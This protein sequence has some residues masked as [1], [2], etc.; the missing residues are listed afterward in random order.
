MQ[1]LEIDKSTTLNE[2]SDRLGSDLNSFL[3]VNNMQRVPNVGE[4]Y[5]E[6][7]NAIIAES[8]PVSASRK[9]SILSSMTSDTDIFQKAAL[10][11]VDG[12]KLTS[13]RNVLPGTIKVPDTI[14]L[15]S[16]EDVLGDGVPVSQGIFK[17]VSNSLYNTNEVDPSIF[18][19]VAYANRSSSD[20]DMLNAI[21]NPNPM[22]I[23][24]IPWGEVTLQTSIYGNT[25]DFPVY[26]EE[27]S[28][29]RKAE[30]TT[31]PDMLYQYEPW[32][33]YTKSGPRTQTYSFHF[34]RDMWTGDHRDGKANDLIRFCEANCYPEY[35]GS[36]VDTAVVTLFIHGKVSIRG[37]L[38]D[39][40]TTW[41]GPIG[42]DGWWLECK[43]DLQITEVSNE[44]LNYSVVKNLP[45][46]G[47]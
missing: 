8:E 19:E 40:N 45:L 28:D 34:H 4:A 12:W 17:Q 3:H 35:R 1:F 41:S 36:A 9:I 16:S 29:S 24:H 46:I 13:A 27:L 23:F 7:C 43:L 39:V 18:N 26:P 22:Q 25:R 38:T 37:I 11:D 6:S 44:P 2:L 5:I 15:P 42:L 20:L 47:R 10:M 33:I 14:Y 32:Q 31:M 30:Y 21:L